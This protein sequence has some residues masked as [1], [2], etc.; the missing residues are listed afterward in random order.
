MAI[1]SSSADSPAVLLLAYGAPERLED[2]EPFLRDVR[3]GRPTPAALLAELRERYAAIGGG[4]PLRARTEEQAAALARTLGDDARVYVGMRHWHPL[5]DDVLVRMR[6]AGERRAVVVPLAPHYSRLSIG[7]YEQRVEE[8]RGPIEVAFVRT[9]HEHPCFLEAVASRVREA[10][11]AFEVEPGETVPVVFTAH[12]LP[13]RILD[14]GDPYRSELEASM[15]GVL[16]RLEPR[17]ARLAFQSAGRTEERWLGPDAA[18]VLAELAAQGARS[19]LLC[20]LGFV[21]DHLE[22][23]YDVDVAYQAVARDLGLRLARTESLNAS[24]LLSAALADTA[25]AAARTQGW[26]AAW[27]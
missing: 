4:S 15:R 18:Q 25:R 13:E 11:R 19:V 20:P 12:S 16:A 26:T 14:E 2:V 24:P 5:V 7:R 21:S 8:A 9:W 23:L 17:P 22:V 3:G 1:A 6:A 10:M 27:M